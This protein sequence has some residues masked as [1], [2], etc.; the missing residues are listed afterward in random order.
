MAV[1]IGLVALS[2]GV[3]D[4]AADVR[5]LLDHLVIFVRDQDISLSDQVR[6]SQY[7][8]EVIAGKGTRVTDEVAGVNVL[9]QVAP[10][11]QGADNWHRDRTYLEAP[12]MGS[13]LQCVIKPNVGGDT[14]W[15]SMTAAYEALPEPVRTM[16]DGLKAGERVVT[17]GQLRL[18]TGTTVTIEYKKYGV[19]LSYTPTVLADGR[20]SKSDIASAQTPAR[21]ANYLITPLGSR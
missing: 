10:K 14:C 21:W 11:G 6:F 7:F 19:S 3:A 20:I 2:A 4:A 5:A 8:G 18:A 1:A 17:D 16:L 15:A 12:P 13:I 9:D